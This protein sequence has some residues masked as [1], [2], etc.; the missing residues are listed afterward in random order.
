[1]EVLAL[2]LCRT[3]LSA[4][5]EVDREPA[6]WSGEDASGAAAEGARAHEQLGLCLVQLDS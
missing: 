6:R 2:A 5:V 3:L 4:H 1:M